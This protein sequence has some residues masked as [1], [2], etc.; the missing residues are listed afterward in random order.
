LAAD[1]VVC[2]RLQRWVELEPRCSTLLDFQS[3][4]L[5]SISGIWEGDG[6]SFWWMF[7]VVDAVWGEVGGHEQVSSRKAVENRN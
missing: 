5:E 6:G 4:F 7:A 3:E 2:V 1:G